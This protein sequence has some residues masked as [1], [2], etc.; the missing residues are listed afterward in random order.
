MKMWYP[1]YWACSTQDTG[2]HWFCFFFFFTFSL[3]H[4]SYALGILQPVKTQNVKHN[5]P[6][7]NRSPDEESQNPNPKSDSFHSSAPASQSHYPVLAPEK[8][9]ENSF[10]KARETV[11][12]SRALKSQRSEN[13][14]VGPGYA[15]ASMLCR[16]MRYDQGTIWASPLKHCKRHFY[17]AFCWGALWLSHHLLQAFSLPPQNLIMLEGM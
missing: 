14:L 5:Q 3:L 11:N 13:P 8:A 16:C 17:P 2:S 7:K 12:R 1:L 6:K 9:L 4:L 10:P 15:P